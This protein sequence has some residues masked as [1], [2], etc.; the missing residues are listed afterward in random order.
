MLFQNEIEFD[1]AEPE[2]TLARLPAAPAVFSLRGEAGEPYL[3][4]TADLRRRVRKLLLPAPAQSRRLH[5]ARLVRRV[6]WTA[7]ASDFGARMLLYRATMAAF[8]DQGAQRMRLRAPFFLR[9]G[10]SNRFPRLWVTNAL[11]ASAVADLFGPF[12]S[13]HAAER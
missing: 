1:R 8:G 13:S 9:M 2:I 7:T 10:M 6:A 5:L 4:H 12:P 11:A 3:N